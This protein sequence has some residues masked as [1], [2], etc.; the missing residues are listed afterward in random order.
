MK[1]FPLI[2]CVLLLNGC[3]TLS[4]EGC[5]NMDWSFRGER[6]GYSGGASLLEMYTAECAPHG[7]V[8]DAVAYAS[9][10][11]EGRFNRVRWWGPP[12]NRRRH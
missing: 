4:A 11:E 5:R 12:G 8:P 7:V 3:A 6:D 9:A 1:N 2:I 10:F